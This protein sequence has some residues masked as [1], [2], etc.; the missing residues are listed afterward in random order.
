M[1]G[2]NYVVCIGSLHFLLGKTLD[3]LMRYVFSSTVLSVIVEF[4]S[5]SGPTDVSLLRQTALPFLYIDLLILFMCCNTINT[6]QH[7]AKLNC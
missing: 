4:F 7:T 6:T 1:I 3:V 5:W 2:G